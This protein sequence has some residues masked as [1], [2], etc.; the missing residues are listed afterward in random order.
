M[1]D[2]SPEAARIQAEI[3]RGLLPVDRLCI[4]IDMSDTARE[5]MRARVRRGHPGWG[6]RRVGAE[7]LRDLLPAGHPSAP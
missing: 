3:Q 5:L 2:T 1:S 4:A 7:M 6:E